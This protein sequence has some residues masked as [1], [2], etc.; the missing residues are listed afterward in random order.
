MVWTRRQRCRIMSAFGR[1]DVMVTKRSSGGLA[2]AL[3]MAGSVMAA[4]PPA[5][6]AAHSTRLILLGTAG[7][8]NVRRFRS[9]PA[10]LLVVD[11]TP[12]LIDAGPGVARQIVWAGF[13]L[14]QIRTVFITH[15]HIDHSAGLVSLISLT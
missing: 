12:Y 3:L 6:P 2:C 11:G 8:P 5:Q 4:Q 7:G 15:H 9:E 14:P 13:Q 10:N 1:L